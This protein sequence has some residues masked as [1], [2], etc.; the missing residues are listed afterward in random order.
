MSWQS[1]AFAPL[2]THGVEGG[3][4]VSDLQATVHK[5]VSFAMMAAQFEMLLSIVST[6]VRVSSTQGKDEKVKVIW[7]C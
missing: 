1:K 5:T 6:C 7:P 3:R 4:R 2:Y